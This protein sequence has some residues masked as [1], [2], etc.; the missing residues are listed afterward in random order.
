MV[1]VGTVALKVPYILIYDFG[2]LAW[3]ATAIPG[4]VSQG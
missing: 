4:L 1:W 3:L 2:G